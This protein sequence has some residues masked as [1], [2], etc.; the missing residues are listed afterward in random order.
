MEFGGRYHFWKGENGVQRN[1]TARMPP[2]MK[3]GR[4]CESTAPALGQN[5]PKRLDAS[6]LL[7]RLFLCKKANRI[8]RNS[9]VIHSSYLELLSAQVGGKSGHFECHPQMPAHRG[10]TA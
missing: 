2:G 1:L 4:H 6:P 9:S 8:N 7:S 3:R 5:V 10:Q